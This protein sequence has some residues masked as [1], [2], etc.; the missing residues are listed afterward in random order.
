MIGKLIGKNWTAILGDDG[1]WV[2]K[3]DIILAALQGQFSS[4]LVS[5]SD[6]VFG[7]RLLNDAAKRLNAT[8]ELA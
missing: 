6:G 4:D 3:N 2:C 7:L 5:E 8:V 1:K